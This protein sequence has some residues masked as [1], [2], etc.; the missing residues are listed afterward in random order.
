MFKVRRVTKITIEFIDFRN[1]MVVKLINIYEN[2]I[3]KLNRTN[4]SNVSKR[5][6]IKL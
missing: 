2:V 6:S 4:G 1:E 5:Y 3:E